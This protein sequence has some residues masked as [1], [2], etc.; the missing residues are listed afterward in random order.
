MCSEELP[1]FDDDERD[2]DDTASRA[3]IR[4]SVHFLVMSLE[5]WRQRC[6][7]ENM[8]I[9]PGAHFLRKLLFHD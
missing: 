4:R 3:K 7:S 8:L 9:E 5:I 1:L 2:D 6:V